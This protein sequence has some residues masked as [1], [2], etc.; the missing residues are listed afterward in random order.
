[1]ETTRPRS[2][3]PL[4]VI[5]YTDGAAIGGAEISLSHLV[6][7]VSDDSNVTVIGISEN[8]V[9]AIASGRDVAGLATALR[10]LPDDLG[11]RVR[12][13]HHSREVAVYRFTVKHMAKNYERLVNTI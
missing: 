8:I 9:D 10:R 1:M 5:V 13:G 7:A 2:D 4:R 12:L 11:L 6:A 3:R